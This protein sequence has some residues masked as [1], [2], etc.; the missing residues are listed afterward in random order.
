METEKKVLLTMVVD[1]EMAPNRCP[2][3]AIRLELEKRTS[4]FNGIEARLVLHYTMG[5][6]GEAG[7]AAQGARRRN[8]AA[9]LS[10]KPNLPNNQGYEI[11]SKRKKIEEGS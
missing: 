11:E 5:G 6:V 2:E 1:L 4:V 10:L 9:N 7:K 8:D 3:D